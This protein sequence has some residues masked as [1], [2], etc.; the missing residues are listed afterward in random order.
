MSE[1]VQ[2]LTVQ[3]LIDKIRR[4]ENFEIVG[5]DAGSVLVAPVRGIVKVK[6]EELKKYLGEAKRRRPRSKPSEKQVRLLE[7]IARKLVDNKINFKVVFE[8]KDIILRFDIDHFVKISER[9]VKIAGF[10]NEKEY[11][12]SEIYDMLSK[13]GK[14]TFLRAVK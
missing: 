2:R 12:I 6:D 11:P 1:S 10:K 8:G 13:H 9:E 3:E 14:V 5:Y 4:F 7:N